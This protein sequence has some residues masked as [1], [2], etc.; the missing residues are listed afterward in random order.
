MTDSNRKLV[1]KFDHFNHFSNLTMGGSNQKKNLLNHKMT[2][3][4]SMYLN[5]VFFI[6]F[7]N[8]ECVK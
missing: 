4:T 8:Q 6:F 5:K 7:R 3:K 2:T 1:K